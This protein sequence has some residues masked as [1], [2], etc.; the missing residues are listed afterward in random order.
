MYTQQQAGNEILNC[1]QLMGQQ[2]SNPVLEI[3]D[4][5]ETYLENKKYPQDKLLFKE[6][7]W[8][9]YYHSHSQPNKVGNEHGH[10]HIF[11]QCERQRWT[12]LV[13]LSMDSQG[14]PLQW[15][16]TNRWVTDECWQPATRLT[17]YI[18][19]CSS[20]NEWLLTEKWLVAMLKLYEDEI[21]SL[22][23]LR[24][25]FIIDL[26]ENIEVVDIHENR[27]YYILSKEMLNLKSKLIDVLH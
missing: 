4:L 18:Q 20:N 6:D 9:A 14:Q 1:L 26:E 22:L 17:E 10:F 16:T 5:N 12:H 21:V 8:Q 2:Q 27:D 11:H 7:G 15:F 13:A 3:L 25:K 24:D 19:K 23:Q